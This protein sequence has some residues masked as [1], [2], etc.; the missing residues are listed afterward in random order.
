MVHAGD[1]RA[2][3]DAQRQL[4]GVGAEANLR[5]GSTLGQRGVGRRI[6][7]ALGGVEAVVLVAV[8]LGMADAGDAKLRGERVEE[9]QAVLLLP[10]EGGVNVGGGDEH[11]VGD[12]ERR[13]ALPVKNRLV[14]THIRLFLSVLNDARAVRGRVRRAFFLF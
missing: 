4:F 12:A 5:A 2:E 14:D 8:V 7:G 9:E 3:R 10:N 1:G 13:L 11:A 6:G